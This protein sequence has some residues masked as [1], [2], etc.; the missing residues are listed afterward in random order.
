MSVVD[1]NTEIV[2]ARP[3]HVV[4]AY[5]SDPDTA[6]A[7]YANIAAVEWKSAKP[8]EVGSRIA[9]VATF[10]GRRLSYTY[11]VT[12]LVPDELFVMRTDEG[13]FPMETTYAWSDAGEGRTRMALR[14][15]GEPSG[16]GRIA[17]P[18]VAAAMRRA[19]TKDLARLRGILESAGEER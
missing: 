12:E 6:I 9:F 8:A 3:R 14:N 19:N 5:A 11:R 7:W 1:V 10:L 4:A 18:V 17:A 13:P 2:I 16:F 15:R